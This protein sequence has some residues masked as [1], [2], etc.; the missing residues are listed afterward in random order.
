MIEELRKESGS[1]DYIPF[2][3]RLREPQYIKVKK[4]CDETGIQMSV[5]LRRMIAISWKQIFDEPLDDE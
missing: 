1:I 5:L 3:L 2:T 4:F